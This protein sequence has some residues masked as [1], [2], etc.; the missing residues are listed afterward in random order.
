MAIQIKKPQTW[1]PNLLGTEGG[2]SQIV[3]LSDERATPVYDLSRTGAEKLLTV[4]QTGLVATQLAWRVEAGSQTRLP[5]GW[6]YRI[7]TIDVLANGSP[8]NVRIQ[9][10]D[11]S[12]TTRVDAFVHQVASGTRDTNFDTD[13]LY[14]LTRFTF[15]VQRP[16]LHRFNEAVTEG[17]QIR[18]ERVSG[19]G[20]ADGT[21][22]A[23]ATPYGASCPC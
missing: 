13:A 18:I 6:L 4:N 20:T 17:F 3:Q 2:K 14:R 7:R 8:F 22:M 10:I 23:A 12:G 11:Q 21:C 9:Y 19:A 15:G 5:A 16:G 1:L